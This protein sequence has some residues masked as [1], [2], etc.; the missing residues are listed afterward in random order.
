MVGTGLG[1]RLGTGLGLAL[2]VH[3]LARVIGLAVLT[4][5]A[6]TAHQDPVS[7]LAS[8]DGGW[9]VRIAQQGYAR[10]LDLTAQGTG[11]LAFYPLYPALIRV[12]SAVGGVSG[13]TA[14]VL[15]SEVAAAVAA[16]GLYTLAARLWD[17]RVAVLIVL[18]WSAQ[19]L[20]IVLCMVYTEALFTALAVWAL[21]ALHR[22]NW[23]AA[24]MLALLA[25]LSRTSGLGVGAAV[26]AYAGWLWWRRE[27][28]S[29]WQPIAAVLALAGAPLWWL[30]VGLRVDRLDAWFVV[31]DRIWGSRWDWGASVFSLGAR[32]FS[33]QTRY[34]GDAVFVI[35]VT[36][37]LLILA[38]VLL[39]EIVV[40]RTWWPL[41]VYAAV[42]LALTIGSDGFI[43]AKPRFLVPIFPLLIPLAT[44]LAGAPR[45]VQLVVGGAVVLA[46]AWFGAYLLV[47]WEYSI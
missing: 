28:R 11:S 24:G 35:A 44:A 8:W 6:H 34:S 4:L 2:A 12:V 45:R 15:I 13:V 19:P 39:V 25:G 30:L 22:R 43:N 41:I 31:Q 5:M 33:Q 36:Y 29:R 37:A 38:V 16:A 18:L 3:A 20:S 40:R 27:Q 21:V 26:A 7:Q 9:Y 14:G 32:L 1:N 46:S 47:V 23:P 10:Q 17:R 42:L